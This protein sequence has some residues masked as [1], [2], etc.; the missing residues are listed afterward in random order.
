[1]G[2]TFLNQEQINEIR[3]MQ[4]TLDERILSGLGI[5]GKDIA[6]EKHLALKTELFELV[7]EVE[8]LALL[9]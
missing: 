7:N 6:L 8:S 5:T 4:K 1:M 2:N 9:L 3:E